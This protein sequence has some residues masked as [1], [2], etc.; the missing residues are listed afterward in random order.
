MAGRV[1]RRRGQILHPRINIG[2]H[3]CTGRG[4]LAVL[5]THTFLLGCTAVFG[6]A[7]S[8]LAT[9]GI[10]PAG[11]SFHVRERS[12]NSFRGRE[13]RPA[14]CPVASP[15]FFFSLSALFFHP[16]ASSRLFFCSS[17]CLHCLDQRKYCQG[18]TDSFESLGYTRI[19]GRL[20]EDESRG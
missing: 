9:D 17:F 15:F 6:T 7:R 4:C 14:R 18:E 16:L 11:S 3:G 13:L 19:A 10:P 1:S 20:D 5:L 12:L 2:G 8:H